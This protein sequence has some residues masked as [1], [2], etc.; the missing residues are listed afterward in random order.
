MKGNM[1]I[2]CVL[3]VIVL[4]AIISLQLIGENLIDVV[5][6]AELFIERTYKGEM[7]RQLAKTKLQNIVLDKE[8][9][10]RQKIEAI[11][12]EFLQPKK[13]EEITEANAYRLIWTPPLS[14]DIHSIA[15]SYDVEKSDTR[16]ISGETIETKKS[17]RMKSNE[18]GG[19]SVTSET[20][21]TGMATG[22]GYQTK[23]SLAGLLTARPQFKVEAE[24]SH[25]TDWDESKTELWSKSRQEQLASSFEELTKDIQ[26]TKVST[27]HL[28]FA[29]D[30]QNNCDEALLFPASATIPVYMG[31]GERR[32]FVLNAMPE[33][34]G[35][36]PMFIIASSATATIKFRGEINTTQTYKLLEFMKADA[37]I[38]LPENG[39]LI[40]SSQNNKIKDAIHESLKVSH[41]V[42]RCGEYEWKVRNTWNNRRVKVREALWAINSLYEKGPFDIENDACVTM[43]GKFRCGPYPG[44]AEAEVY[45]IVEMD[46]RFFSRLGKSQLDSRLPEK[47]IRFYIGSLN[48]YMDSNDYDPKF[49]ELLLKDLLFTAKQEENDEVEC[50]LGRMYENG[51][52]ESKNVQEA[53][54]WYRKAA[55]QGNA[56]AQYNLG[57]CYEYALGVKKDISKAI[58]FYR[59]AA[60]RGEVHAQYHLGWCYAHGEGVEKNQVKAIEWYHSAAGRGFKWAQYILGQ[61]YEFGDGVDKNMEK[62]VEL[63]M[64]AAEQGEISSINSLGRIYS[65]RKNFSEAIKWYHKG[66]EK[67]DDGSMVALGDLYRKEVKDMSKAVEWF[68]MAAERGNAFAHYRLGWCYENGKGVPKDMSE[69]VKW[70]EKG[71]R[72]NKLDAVVLFYLGQSLEFGNSATEKDLTK[73]VIY[74]RMAAMKGHVGAQFNLGYCYANGDGTEKDMAQAVTWYRKAAEQGYATAQCNLGVYYESGNGVKK[75]MTQAITW[76]RKAAEQGNACAQY[77]LGL[78]YVNSKGVTRDERIAVGL[79]LKAAEQGYASAQYSLGWCYENGKGIEKNQS[80]AIEWYR[81]AAEQ[82]NDNAIKRLQEL[83]Q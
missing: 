20:G 47:G 50:L 10:D 57:R 70:Y 45:P 71:M 9:T 32:T 77:N 65:A 4:M 46:S 74:Y 58:E 55:E 81:K 75:D 48:S 14:W 66:A 83:N 27:C 42:I 1:R 41:S 18:N 2:F 61:A 23:I 3:I 36:N 13:D 28:T 76:Y 63:Y 35:N 39:L 38:I 51:I 17:N 78:C 49:Y 22:L 21:S 64:E 59:R 34:I 73:A 69:A 62:A 8:K 33:N 15:I 6:E 30:F 11:Q 37:P 5:D 72:N 24:G 60:E 43:F 44:M 68:R 52:G 25:K 54:K 40:I 16:V 56:V 67:G 29:I 31:E 53:V 80:K 12:K 82:G 19:K 7:A 79:F 26:S